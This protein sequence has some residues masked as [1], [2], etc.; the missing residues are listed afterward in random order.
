MW[1]AGLEE[2]GEKEKRADARR[3]LSTPEGQRT[4][5][6]MGTCMTNLWIL[7][8]GQSLW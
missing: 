7:W 2:S 3:D 4:I 5:S 1:V 8:N 6:F